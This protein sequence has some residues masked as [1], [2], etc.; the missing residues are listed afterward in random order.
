MEGQA[1][2]D[3]ALDLARAGD[4]RGFDVLFR[5]HSGGV[6]RYLRARGVA[7]PEGIANEVFLR[8]FRNI[9]TVR[10]DAARFQSWLFG[11]AHNAAVD[12]HRRVRRRPPESRLTA[13]EPAP[14]GDV[15]HEAMDSLEE[16]A[17]RRL[18][19]QLSPD[20]RDVLLLRVLGDLSVS[21]TAAVLGK[22]FEAVKALQRRA[23]T[24]L[25]QLIA[26]EE[27]VPK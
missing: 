24:S 5:A 12:D 3:A 4:A 18:F 7:D 13:D 27:A 6:T 19:D 16:Q 25:R 11:I 26:N 23:V 2:L 21:Q 14:T 1:G 20:Q 15:E 17:V 10:G 22:S 8:A 9:H